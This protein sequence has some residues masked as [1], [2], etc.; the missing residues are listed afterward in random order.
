MLFSKAF[1]WETGIWVTLSNFSIKNKKKTKNK[2]QNKKQKQKNK[3]TK[4]KQTNEQ[5]KTNQNKQTNK[6]TKTKQKKMGRDS[7]FNRKIDLEETKCAT[8]NRNYMFHMCA[9]GFLD[10]NFNLT[11]IDKASHF[12]ET[13]REKQR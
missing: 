4:N 9:K 8:D 3:Q 11:Y 1:S 13:W 5:N 2:K 7:I 6:Q 10:S 12:G